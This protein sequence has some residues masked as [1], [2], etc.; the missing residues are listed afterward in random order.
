MMLPN[1]Q[2]LQTDESG[3]V[4]IYTPRGRPNPAWAPTVINWSAFVSRGTNGVVVGTQFNGISQASAYGDDAQSATN[5]P[6]VRITNGS[7][8]H[9]TY[10]RTHDHSTM[11]V[12]TGS[13]VVSTTFFVPANTELGV[14]TLQVIANGIASDG[15][16]ITIQ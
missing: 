2:L 8:G 9:V 7:T 16:P 15:V 12:A 6:L 4:E 14:S 11:A 1:G 13:A 3:D 5:Y 10:A